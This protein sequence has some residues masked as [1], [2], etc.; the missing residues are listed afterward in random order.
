M[1]MKCWEAG[2]ALDRESGEV[3]IQNRP[4]HRPKGSEDS[5]HPCRHLEGRLLVG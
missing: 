4:V 2:R 1:N 3:T 5:H